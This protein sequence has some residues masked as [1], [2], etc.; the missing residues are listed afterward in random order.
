MWTVESDGE[1]GIAMVR[2]KV[3]RGIVGCGDGGGV[4]MFK[5][6]VRAAS[7]ISMVVILTAVIVGE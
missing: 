2:G 6:L 1:V 4:L 5:C 3:G 7:M